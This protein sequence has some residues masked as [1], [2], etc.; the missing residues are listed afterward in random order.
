MGQGESC[1][2]CPFLLKTDCENKGTRSRK[3]DSWSE[4]IPRAV[5]RFSDHRTIWFS[6]LFM[7]MSICVFG[8]LETRQSIKGQHLRKMSSSSFLGQKWWF[9]S[10]LHIKSL[11]YF[12]RK[13][14]PYTFSRLCPSVISCPLMQTSRGWCLLAFYYWRMFWLL[15]TGEVTLHS[16]HAQVVPTVQEPDR[17]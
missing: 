13:A 8:A 9:R 16:L 17:T 1:P 14:W 2:P 15:K 3:S 11:A 5:E 6:F 7:V 12:F 4:V 10:Y